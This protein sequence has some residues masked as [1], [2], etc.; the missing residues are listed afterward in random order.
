MVKSRIALTWLE[1]GMTVEFM[2]F[3]QYLQKSSKTA[4]FVFFLFAFVLQ[5]QL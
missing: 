2:N 5:L 3:F 4:E 1:N